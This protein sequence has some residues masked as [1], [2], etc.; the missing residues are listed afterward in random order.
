MIV[1][2]STPGEEK[3]ELKK[4]ERMKEMKNYEVDA[5]V[6]GVYEKLRASA[7]VQRGVDF[8]A[9]DHQNTIAEQIAINEVPAP[10]FQ[11]EERA[12]FYKDRGYEIEFI[13]LAEKD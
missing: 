10:P 8:L 5:T 12:R 11:E 9:T 1:Y 13:D 2:L 6:K 4:K 7:D 3:I